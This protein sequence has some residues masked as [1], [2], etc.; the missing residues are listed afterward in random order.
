VYDGGQLRAILFG[1]LRRRK[2]AVNKGLC[3]R[4][5]LGAH[6]LNCPPLE[7]PREKVPS[8]PA[9]SIHKVKARNALQEFRDFRKNLLNNGLP[10]NKDVLE[11]V[12]VLFV[13]K[14]LE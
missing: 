12:H 14:G 11:A 1:S 10:L 7:R 5:I 2:S 8:S 4:R 13:A 9:G 6:A 3:E